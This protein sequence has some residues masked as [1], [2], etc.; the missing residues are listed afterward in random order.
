VA[1]GMFNFRDRHHRLIRTA[2]TVSQATYTH[3]VPAGT[4]PA[5]DFKIL[6]DSFTYDHGLQNIINSATI[7]VTP[8]IPQD[9]QVVWS[10]TD[11]ITLA[12]GETR[13]IV[14]STT[15]PFILAQVPD[16]TTPYTVDDAPATDYHLAIGAVTATLSRD[17]GQSVFITLVGDAALG[18]VMDTGLNLRAVPLTATTTYKFFDNDPSSIGTFGENAWQ[19]TAPWA[20]IYDA[21]VI[22]QRIVT[23]YSQAR[24]VITLQIASSNGL[25]AGYLTEILA[26]VI[27][28]RITIRNDEMGING[29]YMVER[30]AHTVK[31]LGIKHILELGCQNVEPQQPSNVFTFNTTG[32]GFDQGSFGVA[33]TSDASTMFLFDTVG[34]GF[35]DGRF[36]A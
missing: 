15:D 20:G 3:I 24:P 28:D 23:A 21:D 32:Q 10:T 12:A 17:S 33:G 30:I 35:D 31:K 8:R 27:S 29:P 34:R 25:P 13:V 22:S 6:R 2:S 11:P 18:A 36:A 7:E 16:N 26:R 19:G 9:V 5:G 14:A 1:G 4:G